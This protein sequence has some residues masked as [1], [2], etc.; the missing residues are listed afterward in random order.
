MCYLNFPKKKTITAKSICIKILYLH[1][2]VKRDITVY[3]RPTVNIPLPKKSKSPQR[4]K[5]ILP[6]RIIYDNN[7]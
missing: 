4:Q 2:Y 6:R 7:K 1:L 3:I 5:S